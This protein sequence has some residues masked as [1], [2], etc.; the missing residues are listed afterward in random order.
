M[1]QKS[2]FSQLVAKWQVINLRVVNHDVV[3]L[4]MN[5]WASVLVGYYNFL[6]C[7]HFGAFSVSCCSSNSHNME[8]DFEN[9]AHSKSCN[10][11]IS[12]WDLLEN[13]SDFKKSFLRNLFLWT[14]HDTV[15]PSNSRLF[16]FRTNS[17]I[18]KCA[19]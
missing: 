10:L 19:N 6:F 18:R 9:L 13:W 5:E 1:W 17:R 14:F 3:L 15:V 12:T 7:P 8:D 16:G 11:T 2:L 4:L